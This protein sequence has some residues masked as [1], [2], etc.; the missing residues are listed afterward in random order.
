[1][2]AELVNFPIYKFASDF[3]AMKTDVV[4]PSAWWYVPLRWS[5]TLLV[6][7]QI[8]ILVDPFHNW[9]WSQTINIQVTLCLWSKRVLNV[10]TISQLG[11][12]P[13]YESSTRCSRCSRSH[14]VCGLVPEGQSK[15]KIV[16]M[17]VYPT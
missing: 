2:L 16:E 13:E 7:G 8:Q 6:F 1:M 3:S 17:H 14:A 15:S 4:L 9:A 11:L 12:M 5:Q 10:Q